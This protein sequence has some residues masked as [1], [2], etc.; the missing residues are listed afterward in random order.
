VVDN[1]F[2]VR[3]G[4][5]RWLRVHDVGFPRRSNHATTRTYFVL[6]PAV[7]SDWSQPLLADI[8]LATVLGRE[9]PTRTG[10]VMEMWVYMAATKSGIPRK[11]TAA[12]TSTPLA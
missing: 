8:G 6:F 5:Q 1:P 10:V 11:S 4:G 2:P 3:Q 9:G 7:T 12:P